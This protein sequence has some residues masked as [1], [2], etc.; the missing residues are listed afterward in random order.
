M[1]DYNLQK[2]DCQIS[3]ELRWIIYVTPKPPPPQKKN[4]W[5]RNVNSLFYEWNW[6]SLDETLLQSFFVLKLTD[7]VLILPMISA[8]SAAAPGSRAAAMI[9]D[10][11]SGHVTVMT[12]LSALPTRPED[13]YKTIWP[14][15]VW[16]EQAQGFLDDRHTCRREGSGDQIV[17]G[18]ISYCFPRSSFTDKA[19]DPISFYPR[20]TMTLMCNA[21][22]EP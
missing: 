5:R 4:V 3:N 12:Q 8:S 18:V 21:Q 13:W 11:A 16:S 22:I 17:Q 2:V 6:H 10:S 9:Y 19:V 14:L 7:K 15:A 20:A 1:F